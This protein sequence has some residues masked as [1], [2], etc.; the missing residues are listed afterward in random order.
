MKAEKRKIVVGGLSVLGV[1]M[2]VAGAVGG[3]L[4]PI[5][6]GIGFLLLA[7]GHTGG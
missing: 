3:I 1:A 7:W 5:L 6:T 2:L 4:P